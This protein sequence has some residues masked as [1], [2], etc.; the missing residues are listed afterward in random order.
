MSRMQ[1]LQ[2]LPRNM[3]IDLGGRY[4][5]VPQQELHHTE[6]GAVIEQVRGESMPHRVR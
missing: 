4:V 6:I 3:G 1:L 2:P 5:G